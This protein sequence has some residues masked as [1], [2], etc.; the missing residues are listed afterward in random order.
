MLKALLP[1][2]RP[3]CLIILHGMKESASSGERY[4]EALISGEQER[5]DVHLSGK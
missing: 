3:I 5:E 1:S 2:F 4:L